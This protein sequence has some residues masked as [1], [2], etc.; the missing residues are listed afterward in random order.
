M[1]QVASDLC[2]ALK[3]L[4]LVAL[5]GALAQ[6][7]CAEQMSKDIDLL[8]AHVAESRPCALC[9][10]SYPS[11]GISTLLYCRRCLSANVRML[12]SKVKR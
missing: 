3:R 10:R 2:E 8:E 1:G 12:E 4:R 5:S 7:S 11:D 9:S 6:N